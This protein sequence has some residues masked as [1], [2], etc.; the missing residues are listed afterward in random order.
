MMRFLALVLLVTIF[1]MSGVH[2][3]TNPDAI[4]GHILAG[5]LPKF[6]KTNGIP[7]KLGKDEARLLAL[8]V[9]GSFIGLSAFIVLGVMR[10]FSAL[11]L[12]FILVNVTV[13][14]HVNLEN[15]AATSENDMIQVMKNMSII[16][17]LLFVATSGAR[18][19]A[20]APASAKPKRQ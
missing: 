4:A 20:S 19:A 10:S 18:K 7:V 12:A 6:L 8:A 15:P 3:V 13:F 11:L 9:G 5:G 14:M 16:G 17:G 2:K 1:V